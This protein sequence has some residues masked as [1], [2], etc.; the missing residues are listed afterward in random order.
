AVAKWTLT[1]GW[2][3]V[4]IQTS[5]ALGTCGVLYRRGWF[6]RIAILAAVPVLA[7]IQR[8]NRWLSCISL[9]AP[10]WSAGLV[11]LAHQLLAAV[12]V[13]MLCRP[14]LRGAVRVLCP[15]ASRPV[16]ENLWRVDGRCLPGN[17]GER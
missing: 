4:L 9:P 10:L 3:G 11:L 17:G 6:V 16:F 2:L 5:L 8:I 12:V 7:F 13:A 15:P 1:W 14:L